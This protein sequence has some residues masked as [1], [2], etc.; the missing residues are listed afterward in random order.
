MDAE[1]PNLVDERALLQSGF[2]YALSLRH[3]RHDAEDLVQEAWCRLQGRAR[4]V[5]G[6]ALLFTTIRNLHIDQHRRDKL[7]LFGS[8][9]DVVDIADDVPLADDRVRAAELEP[10]LRDLRPEERET[11]FL[12]A[13][14]GYTAQEIADTTER[15][16]GT[17][18]SLLHRT[19]IKLAR[20]LK[21]KADR[22]RR[23]NRPGALPT[24]RDAGGI[25]R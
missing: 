12:H 6:K 19:K 8:L 9:D 7:I 18:L 22:A 23:L 21:A 3:D 1:E 25:V 14:E 20:A 13:V 15:T 4:G 10:L 11:L 16:R 24:A 17:V 5:E 2:R